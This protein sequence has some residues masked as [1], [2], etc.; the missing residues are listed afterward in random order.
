MAVG[1]IDA[2]DYI[3]EGFIRKCVAVFAGQKS[4]RNNEMAVTR[5]STV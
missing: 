4:G 3:S 2:G 5:G 1:R